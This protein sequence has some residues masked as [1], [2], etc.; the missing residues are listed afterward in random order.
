M[1]FF[2]QVRGEDTTVDPNILRALSG[3]PHVR[4]HNGAMT[5]EDYYNVIANSIVLLAYEPDSYI[6]G[7][8]W[9]CITKPS[10]S[11]RRHW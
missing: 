4:V 10:C 1:Q 2:I 7:A 5:R 11:M 9:A 6:A 8:I 3:Q